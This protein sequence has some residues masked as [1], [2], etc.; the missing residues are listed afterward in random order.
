MQDD[1]GD[2]ETHDS[3]STNYAAK[4]SE[5]LDREAIRDLA[6]R[7]AHAVWKGDVEA[8]IEL[9]SDDC[10]VVFGDD[11]AVRGKEDLRASYSQAFAK[12]DFLPFISSHVVDVDGDRASGVCYLDLRATVDGRSMIGAGYYNDSYIR[13]GD[14]WRFTSRKLTLKFLVPLSEGWAG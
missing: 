12:S 6:R 10:E 5:L 3:V 4:V 9:F 11:P 8:A 2:E 13:I 14:C 7:Y 1:K